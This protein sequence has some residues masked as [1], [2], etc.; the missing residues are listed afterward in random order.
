MLK[1]KAPMAAAPAATMLRG[2]TTT[3]PAALLVEEAEAA[4][5]VVDELPEEVLDP[6]LLAAAKTPPVTSVGISVLAINLAAV[7]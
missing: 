6:E 4:E 2:E 1:A 3:F 7:W 5:V